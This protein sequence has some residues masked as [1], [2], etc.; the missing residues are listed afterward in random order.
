[1]K[2][3]QPIKTITF[4]KNKQIDDKIKKEYDIII[5]GEQLIEILNE[6]INQLDSQIK[7]IDINLSEEN[8]DMDGGAGKEDPVDANNLLENIKKA[9]EKL[10]EYRKA[11]RTTQ[12]EFNSWKEKF[13]NYDKSV[14]I[15]KDFKPVELPDRETIQIIRAFHD[16]LLEAYNAVKQARDEEKRINAEGE[17]A[18]KKLNDTIN[19]LTDQQRNGKTEAERREFDKPI[20]AAQRDLRNLDRKSTRLNSSHLKLSRMPSSA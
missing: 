5:E 13:V 3:S 20:Q 4:Y 6:K 14:D 15:T 19:S 10:D 2:E 11:L 8:K 7:R 18:V 1:M 12:E 17:L 9:S 16:D